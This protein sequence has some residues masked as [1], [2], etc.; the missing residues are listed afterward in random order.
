VDVVVPVVV[1][2]VVMGVVE[3]I[4]GATGGVRLP[5]GS[6]KVNVVAE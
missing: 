6:G 4:T 1:T 5:E 3:T 2:V